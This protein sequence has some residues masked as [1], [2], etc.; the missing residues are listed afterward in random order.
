MIDKI[1]SLVLVKRSKDV[2]AVRIIRVNASI[3]GGDT[4]QVTCCTEFSMVLAGKIRH[5]PI[6][7]INIKT[8]IESG[9]QS[10]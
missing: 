1:N 5:L 9:I 6:D 3:S 8:I 7:H 10:L 2:D 4:A